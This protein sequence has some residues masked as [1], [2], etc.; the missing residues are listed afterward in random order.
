MAKIRWCINKH[1]ARLYLPAEKTVQNKSKD[2]CKMRWCTYGKAD[3]RLRVQPGLCEAGTGEE[4]DRHMW[5]P[6]AAPPS[7]DTERWPRHCLSP[8]PQGAPAQAMAGSLLQRLCSPPKYSTTMKE[9]PRMSV[10][11]HKERTGPFGGRQFVP[12]L[13]QYGVLKDSKKIKRI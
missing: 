9:Q 10:P 6:G 4:Q 1:C 11:E 5:F 8:T 2:G 13:F 12:V 7:M 3:R